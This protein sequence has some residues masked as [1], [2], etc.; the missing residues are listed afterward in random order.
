MA[1]L[2]DHGIKVKQEDELRELD[3]YARLADG[4]WFR[5]ARMF[6]VGSRA[7]V[8][9]TVDYYDMDKI[10]TDVMCYNTECFSSNTT[11]TAFIQWLCV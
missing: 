9:Q 5:P 4:A 11:C 6:M 3:F 8:N 2:C 7:E 10:D 1:E